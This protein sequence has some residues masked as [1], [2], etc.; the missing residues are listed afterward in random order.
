MR[1]RKST[2]E[3]MAETEKETEEDR[4]AWLEG[5]LVAAGVM[6]R[7]LPK[8]RQAME[9]LLAHEE[10]QPMD[11][12]EA[13]MAIGEKVNHLRDCHGAPPEACEA[14]RL[15]LTERVSANVRAVKN[16]RSLV[17][18]VA[19]IAK[20]QETLARYLEKVLTHLG[21]NDQVG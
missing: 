10:L 9:D 18:S 17:K 13:M 7:G 16:T 21:I 15:D 6:K 20:S 3:R 5:A 4:D 14:I 11:E 2:E 1:R 8:I 12:E 19:A